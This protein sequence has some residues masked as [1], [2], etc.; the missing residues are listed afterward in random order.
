MTEQAGSLDAALANARKLLAVKP[1]L[2]EEQAREILKVVPGQPMAVLLLASA[3]RAQNDDAGAFEIL[4]Q[5]AGA[6]PNAAVV[7]FE[8]GN[9]M[10]ALGKTR[11]AVLALTR[12]ADLEPNTPAIWR[13]LGDAYTMLGETKNADRAYAQ[14]IKTSVNDP[15]LIEAATA[16]CENRLAV[17][18]HAL[19]DFLRK[20]PT[21]VAALRMLAETGARLGRY[22]DAEKLLA[23]A[24]ELAPGFDAARHN[25][26]TI[27]HRHGK[28]EDA[29]KQ[30]DMLLKHEPQNP[31]YT[32]LRAAILVRIGEYHEAIN[33]Y[34][35]LLGPYPNSPKSWLSYGHALKTVG[36]ADDCLNAY[37]KSIELMPGL[38]EAYWSMANLKTFRFTGADVTAMRAQLERTDLED[39]ERLQFEFALGKALEDSEDF[40]V[41]FRHYTAGNALRHQSLPEDKEPQTNLIQDSKAFLTPVF[42]AE[43]AGMGCQAPDP[44]FILGLP[45]AGSTLLEQI[46]SSHSAVE[47]TMELPDII[48]IA[49]QLGGK[50]S[51][52]GA[53]NYLDALASLDAAKLKELGEEYL[54]RTRVQRKTDKPFFIDKMPNNFHH[55]ALIH[56]ILPNAKIIDAR[57]HPVAC[58][59]SNFKQHFARGQVFAYDLEETGTYYRDYVELMAHFDAVLPGRIHRVIHE[60]L[61]EDPER[62]VRKVLDYCGLVF[63]ENC[64]RFY[65]NDRAVRT[66][67]SEQVRRPISSEGLNQWRHFEPWLGPLKDALGPVL[68]AY[69]DVPEF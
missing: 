39:D 67:S 27:L 58:C 51:R 44:I 57:R 22:A 43:R 69:P 65:E 28:S 35:A 15:K 49:R 9:V 59:F 7:Q 45:R 3:R 10:A 11:G 48:A 55:I 5:L 23:R 63:E 12:A 50:R 30:V 19:R 21:D 20:N 24:L 8:F 31:N 41:S 18:E 61:V 2:A 16:L 17:A 52:G 36:R 6:H 38:G 64:L 32:T 42:F 40:E 25:Y 56:L 37:R 54:S 66:A 14:N 68:D 60:A 47:G 1:A 4:R 33:V 53:V 62:E 13:A 34:E 26:A 46:L 29:L